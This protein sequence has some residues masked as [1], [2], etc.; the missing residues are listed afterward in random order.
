VGDLDIARVNLADS[1]R[2]RPVDL[3]PTRHVDVTNPVSLTGEPLSTLENAVIEWCKQ[4]EQVLAESEQMRKEADDIG[5]NAELAHWKA[6]MVKFN[7]ITDQLI[8]PDCRRVIALLT[9]AKSR[10]LLKSWKE[11][12][13]RVT[14][15]ANESKD[16]VK[17]LYT[18]ERFYEPLYRTDPLDMIPA[19][20]AL[21]NAIKMIYG[22]S[23]YYNTSERM[24]SLFVKVTNQ[25][26]TSCKDYICLD[27]SNLWQQDR[28]RLSTKLTNCLRL[29]DAYQVCFHDVKRQLQET[30]GAKQFDFS[31]MYIFGKLDAFCKRITKL[32]DMFT[33][34]ERFDQ[35]GQ[36]EIEGVES[37]T[38]RFTMVIGSLQRKPYDMLDHRKMEY[39]FDYAAFKKQVVDLEVQLQQLMNQLFENMTNTERSL[40]LLQRF[41]QIKD[42]PLDLDSK[43]QAV[44]VHY[45]RKD[46]EAV[47][48]LYIK[49]KDKPPIPRN[50]PP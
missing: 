48:K 27:G 39:D 9:A 42:L 44:F 6:R 33:I 18:L 49:H 41:R 19:I 2:L 20:P 28:E 37:I 25:M 22:I 46:L 45:T 31:E 35:L 29:N 16:N 1:I 5:P 7:S 40:T 23:R 26:I 32:M 36:L 4:M 15:A 43:V 11:L 3:E 12:V 38:K 17:Y 50:M 10:N 8:S 47:R 30:P 21:I 13:D 14:D 24:T 34:I